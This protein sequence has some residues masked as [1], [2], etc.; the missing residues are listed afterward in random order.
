MRDRASSS[1][2]PTK[3]RR[4]QEVDDAVDESQVEGDEDEQRVMQARFLTS[5]AELVHMGFVSGSARKP[6]HVN[7]EWF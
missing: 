7:R 1:S 5:L 3:R 6:E 4:E 2:S